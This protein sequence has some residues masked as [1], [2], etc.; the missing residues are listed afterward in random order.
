MSAEYEAR[1]RV[2]FWSKVSRRGEGECWGWTGSRVKG[3]GRFHYHGRDRMAHRVAFEWSGGVIPDGMVIDHLC[4]NRGCVNPAHMEVVT[5]TE[6]TLRG[7]SFSAVNARKTHCARHALP[8]V[9]IG[10]D[11]RCPVCA[12]DAVRAGERRYRAK[13]KRLGLRWN[14]PLSAARLGEGAP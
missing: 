6:N 2:R 3:Y 14:Q 1:A 7:E 11:R 5:V 10:A 9:R 12:R 13:K 8:L 4:R